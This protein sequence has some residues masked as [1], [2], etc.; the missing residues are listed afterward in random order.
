[1]LMECETLNLTFMREASIKK[2]GINIYPPSQKSQ[3]KR[4]SKKQT[5]KQ[6]AVHAKNTLH[7]SLQRT[8]PIKLS[9]SLSAS[10]QISPL[11]K[12]TRFLISN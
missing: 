2:C 11:P 9:S 6:P 1:M 7:F 5:S 4:G 10:A 12:S 8:Q 3:R